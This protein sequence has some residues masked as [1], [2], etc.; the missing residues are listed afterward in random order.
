MGVY[1]VRC[2]CTQRWMYRSLPLCWPVISY[3]AVMRRMMLLAVL[4]ESG[5]MVQLSVTV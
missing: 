5:C 1:V 3:S 2:D 4:S